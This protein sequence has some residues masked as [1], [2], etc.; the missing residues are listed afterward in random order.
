MAQPPQKRSATSRHPSPDTSAVLSEPY[1]LLLCR[2]SNFR[3]ARRPAPCT[4]LPSAEGI[5]SKARTRCAASDREPQPADAKS[6]VRTLFGTLKNIIALAILVFSKAGERAGPSGRNPQ[7]SCYV[8]P[9][10]EDMQ[11]P[12]KRDYTTRT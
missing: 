6:L 4:S 12:Y 7:E 10:H 11:P 1:H 9:T 8:K 2:S 5:R 3:R